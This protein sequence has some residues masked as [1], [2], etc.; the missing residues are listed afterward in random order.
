MTGVWRGHDARKVKWNRIWKKAL[1]L[2]QQI[3]KTKKYLK[4]YKEEKERVLLENV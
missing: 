2:A 1:N 3:I 4:M